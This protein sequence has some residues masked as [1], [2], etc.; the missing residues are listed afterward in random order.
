MTA[1]R[2]FRSCRNAGGAADNAICGQQ[3]LSL[4]TWSDFICHVRRDLL[5]LA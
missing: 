4:N 3:K 5:D 2:A 1:R